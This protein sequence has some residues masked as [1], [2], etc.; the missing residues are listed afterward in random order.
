LHGLS[1]TE[2]PELF[3]NGLSKTEKPEL[4]SMTFYSLPPAKMQGLCICRELIA[5]LPSC[6]P[7]V[8]DDKVDT[9]ALL[10]LFV[11]VVIQGVMHLKQAMFL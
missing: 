2:K 1:K 3:S 4:F 5:I 6:Y 10:L 7:S 11:I 8:V 9:I